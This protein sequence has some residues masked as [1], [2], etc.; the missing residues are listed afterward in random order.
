MTKLQQT[1][2]AKGWSQTKLAYMAKVAQS[3][4]SAIENGW[5]KP[6]PG[7][8]K[9]IAKLLGLKPEELTQA[10]DQSAA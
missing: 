6:Y 10:V 3:D 7:Q 2:D 4:I 9:R 1:R 5:R 8:A